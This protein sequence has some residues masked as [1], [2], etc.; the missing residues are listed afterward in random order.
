MLSQTQLHKLFDYRN[1]ELYWKVSPCN[2][3]KAGSRAGTQN[4][5]GYRTVNI[6]GA[7]YLEH[8]VIYAMHFNVLPRQLD[9][10]DCDKLNNHIENLRPCD[11][12]QNGANR[13][14]QKN[15]SSGV[16]GVTWHKVGQ[17]WGAYIQQSGKKHY[18]GLFTTVAEAE[19]ALIKARANYHGAFT[20]HK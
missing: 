13:K 9:H 7:K 5:N 16:K 10:I 2:T 12:T 8:R 4:A 17:K 11:D 3:V 15:N 18:L 6:K 14:V 19:Q 1:G 20:R